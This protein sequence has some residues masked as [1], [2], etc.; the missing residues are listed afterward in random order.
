[1]S[2]AKTGFL[3]SRTTHFIASPTFDGEMRRLPQGSAGKNK[4]GYLKLLERSPRAGSP[5][6]TMSAPARATGPTLVLVEDRR[7]VGRYSVRRTCIGSTLAA[8][9]AGI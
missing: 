7:V 8:R 5:G 2:S 6:S 1:M 3:R 9:R 4:P